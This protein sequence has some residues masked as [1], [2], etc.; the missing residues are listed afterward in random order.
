[1]TPADVPSSA[2][3]QGERFHGYIFRVVPK[4][5]DGPAPKRRAGVAVVAYPEE[6][7]ISGVMTFIVTDDDGVYE[8]DLGPGTV[9]A[10]RRLDTRPASGWSAVSTASW[11]GK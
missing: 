5:A 8:R 10:A 11:P 6:Y 9:K 4:P 2:T 3:A 7:R 1:V